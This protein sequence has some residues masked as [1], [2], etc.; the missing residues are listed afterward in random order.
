MVFFFWFL[1]TKTP[2]TPSFASLFKILENAQLSSKYI[3][4]IQFFTSFIFCFY[5]ISLLFDIY[6][7]SPLS[8][9]HHLFTNQFSL[10]IKLN[11]YR[12]LLMGQYYWSE[13]INVTSQKLLVYCHCLLQ[14]DHI[15]GWEWVYIWVLVLGGGIMGLGGNGF[16]VDEPNEF[17]RQ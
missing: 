2:F 13:A 15:L 14:W 17:R 12:H 11:R 1:Y 5:S 7:L 4:E 3:K 9:L 8:S 10:K 16:R 6:L